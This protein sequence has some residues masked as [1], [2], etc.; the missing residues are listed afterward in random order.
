MQGSGVNLQFFSEN[1]EWDLLRTWHA[2]SEFVEAGYTY[3]S[4]IFYFELQRRT[5]FY[6]LNTMLP[7]LLNSFLVPVVFMLP[8]DSGEKI[9]YCLTCLLAYVVV[10]SMVMEGLPTNAKYM[11][12]LGKIW[13][14][15]WRRECC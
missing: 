6:G 15:A 11:S 14:Q 2:S 8:H 4:A 10:L 7:V 3:P 5:A 1:G 13:G 12:L 9:G